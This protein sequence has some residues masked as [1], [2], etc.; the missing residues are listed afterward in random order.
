MAV[1]SQRGERW[2]RQRAQM[3][4]VKGPAGWE[5]ENS[6]DG[7]ARVAY[8]RL[9]GETLVYEVDEPADVHGTSIRVR[10]GD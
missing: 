2:W 4:L 1:N 5:I 3:N 10:R 9:D 8:A 7:R 6:M